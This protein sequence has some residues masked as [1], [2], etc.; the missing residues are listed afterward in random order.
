MR[1]QPAGRRN[2][3]ITIEQVAEGTTDSY[4]TPTLT[5][6]TYATRFA[7]VMPESGREFQAAKAVRA[8]LTHLIEMPYCSGVT[9]K[10]RVALGT[11]YLQ[12][13]SVANLEEANTTMRLACVERV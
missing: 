12:I 10:M 11:R 1:A 5:W 9:A 3:H 2:R 13:V 6:S 7:S 8:D 4:G